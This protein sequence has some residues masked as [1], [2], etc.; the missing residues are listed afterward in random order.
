MNPLFS[1]SLGTAV[2]LA[3]NAIATDI[4]L[5]ASL[6]GVSEGFILYHSRPGTPSF[7]PS[8]NPYAAYILRIFVDLLYTRSFIKMAIVLLWTGLGIVLADVYR[9]FFDD[10]RSRTHKSRTT[11]KDTK[12]KTGRSS[13]PVEAVVERHR[14]SP[15]EIPG[16]TRRPPRPN[17]TTSAPRVYDTYLPGSM[18]AIWPGE[19]SDYDRA[20]LS[21]RYTAPHSVSEREGNHDILSSPVLLDT[22][23]D[24]LHSPPFPGEFRLLPIPYFPL[25][26]SVDPIDLPDVDKVVE[27]LNPDDSA[28]GAEV[29]IE[30]IAD[31]AEL[32]E[33][34]PHDPIPGIIDD[35]PDLPDPDDARTISPAGLL[36]IPLTLASEQSPERVV[37]DVAEVGDQAEHSGESDDDNTLADENAIPLPVPVHDTSADHIDT[38]VPNAA[39]ISASVDTPLSALPQDKNALIALAR[40]YRAKAIE[41]EKNRDRLEAERKRAAQEAR[42]RDAFLLEGDRNLMAEK[43]MRY[44]ERASKRFLLGTFCCHYSTISVTHFF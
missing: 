37:Q 29:P 35:E 41:A 36:A 6:V 3:V 25:T 44:H 23:T 12:D 19:Q 1:I 43:A 22:S 18:M 26:P 11:S 17:L 8:S 4:R 21:T 7:I 33:T 14:S 38:S 10:G 16:P 5:E 15:S 9:S 28:I 30:D 34:S 42:P 2:R 40:T 27:P 39:D 24:L 32:D 13:K 20:P 31:G